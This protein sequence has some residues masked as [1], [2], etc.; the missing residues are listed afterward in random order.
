MDYR[1]SIVSLWPRILYPEARYR[2]KKRIHPV[3]VKKRLQDAPTSFVDPWAFIRVKNERCTLL[4]SLRSIL[5]VIKKG[6]IAYND[7]SDGSDRIILDFCRDNPGFIPFHYPHDVVP[8]GDLRYRDDLPFENTL[9]GY[10]TAALGCIPSNEWIIK[11]DVDQVYFPEILRHSFSLPRA[12]DDFVIYSRL[13]LVYESTTNHDLKV[14]RYHRPGDHWLIFNKN[15]RFVN[16]FGYHRNG[17]FYAYEVLK[18]GNASFPKGRRY[19]P[20]CSTLHFPTIKSYRKTTMKV[21]DLVDWD[22][23]MQKAGD[24]EFSDIV[25]SKENALRI[26]ESF[27]WS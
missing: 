10:Y 6:V 13:D 11:I 3:S 19:L 16:N 27:D 4:S 14:W 7:C 1:E 20:E 9:A 8:A 15:L 26:L 12:E 22:V 2:F 25:K 23:W 5:P 17:R 24:Q 18:C 21:D